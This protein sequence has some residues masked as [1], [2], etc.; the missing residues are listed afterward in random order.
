MGADGIGWGLIPIMA[1]SGSKWLHLDMN[2]GLYHRWWVAWR[3]EYCRIAFFSGYESGGWGN[4]D[5]TSRC[6]FRVVERI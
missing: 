1:T 4:W 3:S 6:K 2:Y 5:A